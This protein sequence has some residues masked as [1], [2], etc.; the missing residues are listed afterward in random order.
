MTAILAV[1]LDGKLAKPTAREERMASAYDFQHLEE[2]VA[3]ADAVL[4]GATT[5]RLG[6]TAMRLQSPTLIA[7]RVR[8][9]QPPQPL[10]IVC[11][12]SGDLDP[13]L[14]FFRQPIPRALVTT[15]AGAQRWQGSA[16]FDYC[17]FG[18]RPDWDWSD[19]LGQIAA[20]GIQRLAVLGGG[21]LFASLV[22]AQAID[23]L[24]LTVCPLLL[25]AAAPSLMPLAAGS[26]PYMRL[27]S[28]APVA[29]EVYLH[30]RLSYD[31]GKGTI[32]DS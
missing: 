1:S 6:G 8:A 9:G 12:A 5:L 32:I 25:G 29:D 18:D 10:Q 20:A 17:W 31:E 22:Q 7:A 26:S 14:P 13:E 16:A 2:Q 3:Q 28:A 27:L 19:L 11:S 15:V 30:Y 23:E 24:W 4:F 21:Q